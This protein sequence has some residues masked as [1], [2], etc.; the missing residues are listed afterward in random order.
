MIEFFVILA[1]LM[2][3]V[4]A[5]GAWQGGGARRVL[6]DRD[7]V[8]RRPRVVEE[9]F[10]DEPYPRPLTRSRRVVRRRRSW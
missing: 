5:A 4:A 6:Y 7:V 3:L 8:D 10:H 1:L 2:V 9:E